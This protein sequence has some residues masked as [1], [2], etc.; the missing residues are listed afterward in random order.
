MTESNTESQTVIANLI[1]NV[2]NLGRIWAAHGL[3]VGRMTLEASART[4]DR[5]A[6]ALNEVAKGIREPDR[7]AKSGSAT[8]GT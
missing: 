6:E 5:T 2:G 3:E 1:D 4:L 8:D 7:G